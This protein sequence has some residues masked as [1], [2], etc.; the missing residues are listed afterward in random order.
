MGWHTRLGSLQRRV[1]RCGTTVRTGW[2]YPIG[3]SPLK[4]ALLP[5]TPKFPI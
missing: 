5:T 2:G 1:V 3:Q 4:P